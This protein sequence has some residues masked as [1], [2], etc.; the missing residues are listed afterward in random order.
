[1]SCFVSSH[2]SSLD[3]AGHSNWRIFS[4]SFFVLF[5]MNR[6]LADTES[7]RLVMTLP[8][9]T[10]VAIKK[11]KEMKEL[12]ALLFL[13]LLNYGISFRMATFNLRPT[14][15]FRMPA[16]KQKD[17]TMPALSSTMKEGKIVSWNKKIGEKV[18]SGEVLLVV[19]SDKADMDVEAFEDGIL[20]AIFTPAGGTAAVGA[21]V[22]SLVDNAADISKVQAPGA[23]A[24]S[25]PAPATPS[26]EVK[27]TASTSS[28][29][30]APTTPS[31]PA[32]IP[33]HQQ[34][35][36]PALSSTMKEGKIVSW[37][38]KV[39]DK[40]SSGDMVLVVESDKA[41]MDV[42]SFEEGYLAAILVNNGEV[43]AVGAPVA[44]L[45]T[46]KETI[47]EVQN[48]AKAGAPVFG[49]SMETEKTSQSSSSP[50]A[51]PGA[52]TDSVA[53]SSTTTTSSS[54][55]SS[56]S[57]STPVVVNDGRISAS[58][59][60]KSI[61]KEMGIDLRTVHPSRPD[62]YIVSTDLQNTAPISTSS[63][64]S[65]ASG[66][67]SAPDVINA[68]PTAKKLAAEN[69]LEINKISGTGPYGRVTPED[70]LKAAGKYVP[71]K[72]TSTSTPTVVAAPAKGAATTP[73]TAAAVTAVPEGI[74]EMNGM[75]KAVVKNMEH[76]LTVPVFRVSR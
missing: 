45:A 37:S 61:A 59:Y 11:E 67:K 55:S 57:S 64:I 12:W 25:T 35:L 27:Q 10:V 36:M 74:V 34:I 76:S 69:N 7:Y 8:T 22:A 73:A 26:V 56:S 63:A 5:L 49:V 29:S 30:S 54:S 65:F 14:T 39:G 60:A 46:S 52:A 24:A 15:I 66:W 62:Q 3:E 28:S 50:N 48:Y 41:D 68:T 33:P 9:K 47:V 32:N 6:N 53:S 23:A 16:V 51:I 70:V 31:P 21:V 44:Y 20:A 40:I 17:I 18:Q 38:K 43:A 75:Q 19:E 2:L 72:T 58:G 1:M 4:F 13:V 42:E 71:P